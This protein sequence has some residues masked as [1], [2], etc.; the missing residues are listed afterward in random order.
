MKMWLFGIPANTNKILDN[1]DVFFYLKMTSDMK[2]FFT[3]SFV[4]DLLKVW[5]FVDVI[6]KGIPQNY[7][8]KNISGTLHRFFLYKTLEVFNRW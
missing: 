1:T 8:S 3:D 5:T 6:H 4:V 2:F 7:R